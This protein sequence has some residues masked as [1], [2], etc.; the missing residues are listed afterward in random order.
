MRL[1]DKYSGVLLARKLFKPGGDPVPVSGKVLTS[2]DFSALVDASLDGWL[3]VGRFTVDFE[4]QLAQF[5]G[6]RSAQFVNS[7]SSAN[8]VVLN[9]LISNKLGERA[10]KLGDEV[11]AVAMGFPICWKSMKDR[12]VMKSEIESEIY[13][14]DEEVFGQ[15]SVATRPTPTRDS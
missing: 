10:L 2:D 1:T 14:L 11:L 6:A 13:S 9:G 7:G 12:A 4:R 5:V 8:L 3:T 15:Q